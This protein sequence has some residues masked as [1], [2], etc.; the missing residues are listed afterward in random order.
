MSEIR[1]ANLNLCMVY[2]YANAYRH[3]LVL[4]LFHSKVGGDM[5]IIEQV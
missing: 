5:N 3:N 4:V 1:H 2:S